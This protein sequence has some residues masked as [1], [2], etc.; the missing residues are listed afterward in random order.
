MTQHSL[1]VKDLYFKV[2]E[3]N[4]IVL[5]NI[6]FEACEGDFI[7]LLGSNG[8]G[9]SSLIK[10]LNGTYFPQKGQLSINDTLISNHSF[11]KRSKRM[12]TLMQDPK[13]T[14]FENLS[15][16]ENLL[17]ASYQKNEKISRTKAKE[18]LLDY[19]ED[20]ALDL[21]QKVS[22]LSGGQKQSLAL[23][24]C[25]YNPPKVLFLDEHTS[26]LDPVKANL[27]MQLTQRQIQKNPKLTVIMTT[28]KL[29]DA[30]KYGNRIIALKNGEIILDAKKEKKAKMTRQQLLQLY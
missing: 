6:N 27:M 30:L 19:N 11:E 4:K 1:I 12:T 23:A 16:Y 28:H 24:L 2:S 18:F 20:L 17:C 22:S 29:D 8:S 15:V 26:A 13:I 5:N 9:K 7:I 10:C 25:L 3:Q 21:D 14:T